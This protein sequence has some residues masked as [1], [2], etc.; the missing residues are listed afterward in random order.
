MIAELR[1]RFRPEPDVIADVEI[2]P[3]VGVRVH[4]GA[5]CAPR[6]RLDAALLRLIPEVPAPF[7]AQQDASPVGADIEIVVAVVVVVPSG[8]PQEPARKSPQTG[9]S[10]HIG[11]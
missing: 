6:L 10:R 3:A 7:V 9:R 4:K 2:E 11:E 1:L 5:G 8:A